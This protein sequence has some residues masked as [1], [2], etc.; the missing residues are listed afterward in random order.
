[1]ELLFLTA[2]VLVS[3]CVLAVHRRH[4]VLAW[5]RELESAFGVAEHRELP[6]HGRL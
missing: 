3:L 4:Q 6:R 1:M 2:L 5:D